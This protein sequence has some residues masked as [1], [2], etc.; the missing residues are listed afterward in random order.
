MYSNFPSCLRVLLCVRVCLCV[1]MRV[2]LCP[3]NV[4]NGGYGNGLNSRIAMR[5]TP[6]KEKCYCEEENGATRYSEK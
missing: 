4:F 2:L 1:Y 3:K 6:R 5:D